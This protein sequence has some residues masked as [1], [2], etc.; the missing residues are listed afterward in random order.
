MLIASLV[1][2]LAGFLG[3]LINRLMEVR[4]AICTPD[5]D[6][7]RCLDR[8]A[9]AALPWFYGVAAAW[10]VPLFLSLTKSTLFADA[11]RSPEELVVLFGF[12]IVAAL[13]SRRFLDNLAGKVFDALN[14]A[15]NANRQSQEAITEAEEA[16]E[17]AE[18]AS[19]VAAS[20]AG[21]S[22]DVTVHST[23]VQLTDDEKTVLRGFVDGGDWAPSIKGVMNA[24]RW[25]ETRCRNTLNGLTVKQLLSELPTTSTRTMIRWVITES[26][27]TTLT[28]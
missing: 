17:T 16:K 11:K 26:G 15:N 8:F 27:R 21:P 23:T 9:V 24:T 3:G 6:K 10:C 14:K 18:Q 1:L 19:A 7:V 2:T 28:A 25:D 12:G 22:A 13:S 4:E 5:P 20:K